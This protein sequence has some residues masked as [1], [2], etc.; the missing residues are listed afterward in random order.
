ME[1]IK[2][3]PSPQSK[4]IRYL[5]AAILGIVVFVFIISLWYYV[6]SLGSGESDYCARCHAMKPEYLTWQQSSH[7]QFKCS[8]CHRE[9]GAANFIKY[10]GRLVKEIFYYRSETIPVKQVSSPV[11]SS[12]CLKCH[13]ENRKY[14]PSSDTVIPHSKHQKKGIECTTCHAGIAHGRIVERGMT[15]KLK[16]EEWNMNAAVEQM[17]FKYTTPRMAIC[18]DCHAKRQVEMTCSACHSKQI[19]PATHKSKGWEQRHGLSAKDNF[20]PC[21]L[22]H[23]YTL[24]KPVDVGS[25]S[26][27]D[28]IKQNSYCY[29][30]HLNKPSTHKDRRFGALHGQLVKSRGIANCMG[31]HD[32]NKRKQ[33]KETG[34]INEVYCNKCHWFR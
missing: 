28:Y 4:I 29:N 5:T 3:K 11:S 24:K 30:C 22:C 7:S 1:Q 15:T 9:S 10:Q 18:L 33:T 23:V 2:A 6:P 20:K 13:S 26:L 17:D 14:S 21:N 8:V 16:A 34:T 32:L 12:A 27:P 25:I 19:I 31:C